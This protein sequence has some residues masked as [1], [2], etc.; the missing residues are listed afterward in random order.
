[1]A[2]FIRLKVAHCLWA[3]LCYRMPDM[4]HGIIRRKAVKLTI[5]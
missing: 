4:I 1:M 5:G 3:L 2:K